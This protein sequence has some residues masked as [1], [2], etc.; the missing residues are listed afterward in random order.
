MRMQ[1]LVKAMNSQIW[2]EPPKNLARLFGLKQYFEKIILVTM[3]RPEVRTPPAAPVTST[4]PA[5]LITWTI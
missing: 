5:I 4:L 1:V 3:T 2:A